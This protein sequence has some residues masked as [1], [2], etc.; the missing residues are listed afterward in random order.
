[1]IQDSE[2]SHS[3][4]KFFFI[5]KVAAFLVFLLFWLHS[6]IN[7]SIIII[8][9][10]VTV[11]CLTLLKK[12]KI[13]SSKLKSQPGFC[14]SR[15][16]QILFSNLW[17]KYERKIIIIKHNF[18]LFVHSLF[19]IIKQIQSN[20]LKTL[21]YCIHCQSSFSGWIIMRTEAYE[22]KYKL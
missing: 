9:K 8:G 18:I 17:H 15:S 4:S 20:S 6:S 2:W 21:Y 7:Q 10:F 5:T 14:F 13:T 11:F 1:M 12:K 16:L 3:L 22:E 19:F